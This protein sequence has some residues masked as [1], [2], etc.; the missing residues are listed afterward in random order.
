M[1]YSFSVPSTAL[2]VSICTFVLEKQENRVGRRDVQSVLL[3]SAFADFSGVSGVSI[4]T[5]VLVKQLNA[6]FKGGMKSIV[7]SFSVPADPPWLLR[8]LLRCQFFNISV[9]FC[10]FLLVYSLERAA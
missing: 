6:R 10:T 1:V 3:L 9:S 8:Q 5:V 7:Y 4:C 2:C